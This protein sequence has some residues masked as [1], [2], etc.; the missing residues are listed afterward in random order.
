MASH[1]ND[2]QCHSLAYAR[3]TNK[4]MSTH[5]EPLPRL[6]SDAKLPGAFI[7]QALSVT[8]QAPGL[9]HVTSGVGCFTTLAV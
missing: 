6:L 3:S 2:Y 7:M 9:Y 4:T 1:I 5:G 8:V